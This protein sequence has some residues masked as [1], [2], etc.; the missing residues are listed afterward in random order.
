MA[1]HKKSQ[2][3]HCKNQYDVIVIGGGLSGM[4]MACLLGQAGL[5]VACVDGAPA[6]AKQKPDLRT[7]AISYGSSRILARA[8]FWQD[9]LKGACPI[10]DIKILDGD[11]PV[12]LE[13]LSDRAGRGDD[14]AFGWIV[15]NYA[16]RRAMTAQIAKL[17]SV[18]HMT[19]CQVRA[20][21][22][23]GDSAGCTLEDGR[24]LGASLIIG[25][26][27]RGSFV[28]DWL[29]IPVRGWDY[30][31]SAVICNVAHENPHNNAAIEH[32]WPGGPFAVLPM[33]DDDK[34]RHRSSVVFTEHN[35]AARKSALMEMDEASFTAALAARFPEGYGA[36]ELISK[37]ACYPLSLS[38]ARRYT[39][40]RAVLIADAAHGI[41][42]IA[43]QGLNL[44]FRDAERLADL[45][46][47]AQA[48][49]N[50]LGSAA[51]LKEYETQRL[52]DNMRMVGVTDTLV[53]LFSN[54]F[55]PVR[56]LRRAGLR[57]VARSGRLKR[58]LTRRAMGV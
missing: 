6:I 11:S 47:R 54:D 22:T 33:S 58:Y 43:G 53:K 42:P 55:A 9:C 7:T 32:F 19:S 21:E 8:G 31:Q 14:N 5:S 18:E 50:D 4:T 56:A 29:D 17:E 36:L 28:R 13:F 45:L 2:K 25:A 20:L 38:H 24:S 52:G 34:G 15:E 49:G 41:H 23:G 57:A 39:G 27:G 10:T 16:L 46:I 48:K 37:R 26:D 51:L 1:A 40:E 30:R 44:G 3:K 12:L 35:K